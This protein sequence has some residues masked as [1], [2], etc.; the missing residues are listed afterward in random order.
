MEKKVHYKSYKSGKFWVA[1]L[2]SVSLGTVGVITIPQIFDAVPVYADSSPTD[3]TVMVRPNELTKYFG[4]FGVAKVLTNSPDGQPA[5]G[6]QVELT[7]NVASKTGSVAL[8][9]KIDM[10][11][12]FTLKGRLYLGRNGFGADGVAFGFADAEPGKMGQSGN[13][14]GIGGLPRSFGVKFDEYYNGTGDGVA[15]PD[16][17]TKNDYPQMRLVQTSDDQVGKV[18]S[19][20]GNKGE[21]YETLPKPNGTFSDLVIVYNGENNQMTITYGGNKTISFDAKP[22]IKN[23]QLA[24]FLTGSTGGSFNQHVFDFE[25]FEYTPGLRAVKADLKN[26]L[27]IEADTQKTAVNADPTLT[28][29][30]RQD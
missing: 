15:G 13:A 5:K 1:A 11:Q 26:R 19:V 28:A 18:T 29:K 22:Y 9:T 17:G 12:S 21:V 10:T 6:V 8:L 2:I 7:P 20:D 23:S 4:L 30:E 16:L 14:F 27:A 25:S 24:M 3:V